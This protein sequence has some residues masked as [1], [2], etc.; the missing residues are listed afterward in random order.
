MALGTNHLSNQAT[1]VQEFIPELWSDDIIASY[2]Q[3]LVLANLVS[4]IN[5]KGKKG[6][7]IHI[8]KP[9][10]GSAN[11]KVV[12][13]PVTLNEN[14]SSELTVVLDKHYEYSFVIEDIIAIQA[15]DSLRRFQTDDAGYAL[16]SQVDDDLW[17]LAAALQ[18]G[19][20]YSAAV[21]G[22]DG[23]TVWDGSANTNTGNGTTLTDAGI[24][25]MSQLLDDANVPMQGRVLVIPPV[26]K[27][28]LLGLARFTEQAFVGEVGAGNSIRNGKIGD[29]YGME[30]YVSTNC[31]TVA[32]DD[33]T[34]N[35]RVG[36]MFHK[37]AFVLAEQMGV[38]T[39]STYVQEYLGDLF[40]SDMIYGIAELRDDAGVAF[41]VPQ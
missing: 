39:Q 15:L 7:T 17:T 34:T 37:D 31:P 20:S 11:S 25:E 33:T 6:D 8:P 23:V 30:V 41:F 21:I 27:N 13:S 28:T 4:K 2:K 19:T 14:N 36:M 1:S 32:A 38:R 18:G 3:N 29:I 40:T 24:R 10:R 16:A 12:G 9:T 5:H 35:Y 26:E 22:G